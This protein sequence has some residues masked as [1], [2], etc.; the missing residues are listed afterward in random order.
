[1]SL[2]AAQQTR[3]LGNGRE[4]FWRDSMNATC[5]LPAATDD[6]AQDVSAVLGE[7][8]RDADRDCAMP[9][10]ARANPRRR[11]LFV[12]GSSMPWR[13]VESDQG[14]SGKRMLCFGN[15]QHLRR[16][17]LEQLG[18][19]RAHQDFVTEHLATAAG[20]PGV[21]TDGLPNR[22]LDAAVEAF[23]V[24]AS[25]RPHLALADRIVAFRAH[26]S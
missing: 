16:F 13:A 12:A 7:L 23:H 21:A 8:Q 11:I 4:R 19:E 3:D 14:N 10:V 6:D 2:A 18:W 20:L 1:M 22:L 25:V 15:A 9:F 24:A 26:S 17:A 5:G